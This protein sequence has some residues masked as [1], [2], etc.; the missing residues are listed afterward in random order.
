M[1][2][3]HDFKQ[4]LEH[5]GFPQHWVEHAIPYSQL[6]K[7]LKKILNELRD[8]G[9]DSETIKQLVSPTPD[10]ALKLQYDLEESSKLQAL[11]PRLSIFIH[12]EDG[13]PVDATLTPAS[14][15]LL[16]RILEKQNG[17][18]PRESHNDLEPTLNETNEPTP[19]HSE[20]HGLPIPV[21]NSDVLKVPLHFDAQFFD[22]LQ[23]EMTGLELIQAQEEKTLASEIDSLKDIV[24]VV[25]RPSRFCRTDI[26]KWREIFHV[27]IEAEVFFSTCETSSG[28]RKSTDALT[29]LQWFHNE[30]RKLQL[31]G[32][33]SRPQS[34]EALSRFLQLNMAILKNLQFQEINRTA[35]VKI[36]KKF[37][38]RTSFGVSK[39]FPQAIDSTRLMSGSTAKDMCAAISSQL[40]SLVPQI[41]DYLCP[42]CFAI[43]WRAIR[44]SCN[45]VFCIRCIIKMQR[46]HDNCP[47]CRANSVGQACTDNL[48]PK[49]EHFL[50]K[51]FRAE[52]NEKSVADEIE[53]GIEQ[54]GPGYRKISCI[55]M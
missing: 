28:A 37:D 31:N 50:K 40:V 24:A 7:C 5:E 34:R 46:R 49:L 39:V 30:T 29:K 10:A 20:Q 52:V 14:K 36:L 1:K 43:A 18:E 51:N 54:Y 42:V 32:G 15:K 41:D 27:Y 6:K 16:Q 8:L 23:R 47:L 33:F 38:K 26:R 11:K 22:I 2:F 25:S 19:S 12:M 55:V 48:D 53:T 45:H 17:L 13:A 4:A 9:L 44:L 21:S 3:G 35:I